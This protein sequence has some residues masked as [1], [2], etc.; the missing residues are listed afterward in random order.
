MH[1]S[2]GCHF[3]L[4]CL[5]VGH[6]RGSSLSHP[7]CRLEHRHACNTT[8]TM[9]TRSMEGGETRQKEPGSL[10]LQALQSHP[11]L[12]TPD[13]YR[14]EK[15]TSV[16]FKLPNP[17]PSCYRSFTFTFN[18]TRSA[19]D[20]DYCKCHCHGEVTLSQVAGSQKQPLERG[21]HSTD[22]RESLTRAGRIP[23]WHSRAQHCPRS[24]HLKHLP[25]WLV[26]IFTEAN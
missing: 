10:N 1:K 6:C 12:L 25:A 20:S 13:S 19:S 23:I 3:C 11:G 4:P 26:V 16:F 17:G 2:D 14:R 21:N 24:L 15:C 18:K 8:L 9:Q 22:G 5:K 7:S